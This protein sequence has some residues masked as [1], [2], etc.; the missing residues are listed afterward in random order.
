[1]SRAALTSGDLQY[2]DCASLLDR[3]YYAPLGDRSWPDDTLLY[4]EYMDDG[5][6]EAPL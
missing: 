1:M 3:A 5:V 6:K 2:C 4:L